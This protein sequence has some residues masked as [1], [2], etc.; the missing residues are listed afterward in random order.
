MNRALPAPIID[1]IRDGADGHDL[2]DRGE[3]AVWSALVRTA[4]S[5]VQRG[6]SVVD[7]SSLVS[8]P[9]S[10]LGTQARLKKG[11]KPR[12]DRDFHRTLVNAWTAAEK[13]LH[14]Q[15]TAFD[16]G[17]IADRI[18][19]VRDWAAD[20]DVPLKDADRLV[21]TH[22]VEVALRN[23]TDR[24]ALPR[25]E[26]CEATGLGERTVRTTL[27]RLADA[28]LLMLEVRGRSGADSSRRRASLYRLPDLAARNSYL[29]RETRSMGPPAQVYGTPPE[30][31]VGTPVQIYGTPT[32]DSE[33]TLS[34]K[35][36]NPEVLAQALRLLAAQD[37]EVAQ[38]RPS[39]VVPIRAVAS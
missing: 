19:D 7:W 37:V 28:G 3:R 9:H 6:W 11:G 27:A 31:H 13:W 17:Q 39:N 2:R 8:E 21:L 36:A 34:I 32:V 12:T 22:A 5:A 35:A 23:G 29:Y 4:C 30:K 33:I 18:R 1:L 24:P 15:P 20:G 16:R 10:R 25:R 38:A 14:H 26:L